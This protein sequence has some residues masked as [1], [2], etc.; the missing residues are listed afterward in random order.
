MDPVTMLRR[1]F[2]CEK[3]EEEGVLKANAVKQLDAVRDELFMEHYGKEGEGEVSERDGAV[4]RLGARRRTS[5]SPASSETGVLAR[6]RIAG[7]WSSNVALAGSWSSS[8]VT[9]RFASDR[10]RGI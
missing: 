1:V 6:V 2:A 10:N 3:E 8:R 4:Q 7:S 5:L 9:W